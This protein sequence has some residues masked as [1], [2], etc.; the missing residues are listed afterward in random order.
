[1][2]FETT[3]EGHDA[4]IDTMDDRG[5]YRVVVPALR[6]PSGAAQRFG[7]V[8]GAAA[9]IRKYD[10]AQR[11]GFV[12]PTAFIDSRG[13][14]FAVTV[15]SISQDGLEC[16][17]SYATGSREKQRI[18]RLYESRDEVQAIIDRQREHAAEITAMWR[19]AK[20]WEPKFPDDVEAGE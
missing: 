4:W 20:R 8:Q 10:L 3:I 19:G 13:V 11:K 9:A 14:V 7:S 12:N 6:D 15:T 1:M 16:W 17:V 2:R 5:E 18:D